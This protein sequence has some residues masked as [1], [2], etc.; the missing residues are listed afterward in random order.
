VRFIE[1]PDSN[2]DK[3]KSNSKVKLAIR[4][5]NYHLKAAIKVKMLPVFVTGRKQAHAKAM[6]S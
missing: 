5:I 4:A 6:G 1:T 2:S 3:V